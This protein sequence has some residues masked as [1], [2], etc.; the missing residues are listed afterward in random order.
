[1]ERGVALLKL[2]LS[3][4]F[5]S[6]WLMPR[7]IGFRKANADIELRFDITDTKRDFDLDDVDV[8]IRFGGGKYPGLRSHRLFDDMVI[9]V[10]SPALL[11]GDPPLREPRDLLN[12]TLCHVD[13]TL[14]GLTWPTWPM[15]MAAAGIEDFDDSQC[16]VF[17]DSAH[18]VQA[19]IDGTAVAL[20]DFAMVA[21][22]LSTGRL[23]RP[24]DLGIR[25]GPGFAYFLVYPEKN[26]DDPRIA[27]FRAW[28]LEQAQ[29]TNTIV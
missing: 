29:A 18:A 17:D 11:S 23:V 12:H 27:A 1:M 13:W 10:C 22:D 2:T 21:A 4:T 5:A 24:F 9:P 26:A 6:K 8:G 16:V 28:M 3:P 15:W 25:Y 7:L 20:A 19:A 14:H